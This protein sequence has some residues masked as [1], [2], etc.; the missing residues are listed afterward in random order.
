MITI[1]DMWVGNLRDYDQDGYYSYFNLY[2]DL[3]INSGERKVFVLLAIRFYDQADTSIYV[4]L[5]RTKTFS[6]KEGVTDDALFFDVELPSNT[7]PVT[8]YDFLFLVIR[9]EDVNETDPGRLRRLAETS[10]TDE[11]LLSNVP[12]EHKDYDAVVL[13]NSMGLTDSV[14]T[15]G[16]GFKS[17]FHANFLLEAIGGSKEIFVIL[18]AREHDPTDTETYTGYLESDPFMI[19]PDENAGFVLVDF[20]I[21]NSDGYFSQGGYD[22]LFIVFDNSVPDLRLIEVSAST[23]SMLNNV[24]I[25][26]TEID[27]KILIYDAWFDSE[28]GVDVDGDGFYSEAWLVFDIDEENGSGEDVF[29]DIS[30]RPSGSGTYLPLGTTDAF[31][32]NGTDYDPITV[33]VNQNQIL[34]NDSYDFRIDL[35]FDGYD[36]IEDWTDAS[37]DSDLSGVQIELSFEDQPQELSVWNIW[38]AELFDNDRDGYYSRVVISTDIDVSYGEADVFIRVYYKTSAEVTYTYLGDSDP[39]TV[40]GNSSTDVLSLEFTG[41]EHGLWDL[42]FEILFEG[43]DTVE[44]VYDESNEPYLNDIFM[45]TAAEDGIP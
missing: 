42:R 23:S 39:V 30:Y 41:F 40:T 19:D 4:E 5:L 29:V 37:L 31:T 24:L 17:S 10:A 43:S 33:E 34:S 21:D 38:P 32:I 9:G 3:D 12:L 13:L 44:L 16:D 8:G 20:P 22:F 1:A 2:F 25:E 26:P 6:V 18:A 7:F 45:E 14:D 36:T 28:D 15:D 35:K 27:N 11:D